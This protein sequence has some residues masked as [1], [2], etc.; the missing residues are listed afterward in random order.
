MIRLA[1]PGDLPRILEIYATARSFM[2]ANG[3]PNQWKDGYPAKETLLGDIAAEK[4]YVGEENGTP[5]GVFFLSEGPDPTYSRIDGEGWRSGT[6]YGVIHRIASDGTRKGFLHTAVEF[7]RERFSHLRINTHED[8]LPMQ[9]AL[10]KEGFSHRGTI[11]LA[12]GD[13][14]L[15]YDWLGMEKVLVIGCPGGGKSTFARVLRDKTNLPLYSLDMIWH[16]PDKTTVTREEFDARLGELLKEPRFL[17]EGN[18]A[19]TLEMRLAACDTVFLLDYPVEVCLAG[20]ESRIGTKREDMP[21]VET[22]FDPEFREY[23][24]HFAAERLPYIYHCLNNAREK[25]VVIFH[26]RE[27]AA[28]FLETL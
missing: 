4:L 20:V 10:A 11:Y 17:I 18:Y 13:P 24:L 8:N 12:N 2:R 3:N 1:R 14:R 22:E 19:R 5:F 23:I 25:R 27:E 26:G 9:N 21:W 16:K 6:S 28:D 15:A 7:A